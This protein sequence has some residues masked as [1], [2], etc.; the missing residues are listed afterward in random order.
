MSTILTIS[1]SWALALLVPRTKV[2]P[3]ECGLGSLPLATYPGGL[4][5]PVTSLVLVCTDIK[6]YF[7]RD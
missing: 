3:S 1:S 6:S 2:T 5:T 4:V 7:R